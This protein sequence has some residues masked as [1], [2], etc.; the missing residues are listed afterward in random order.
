M[1]KWYRVPGTDVPMFFTQP[2]Q[3][4]LEVVEPP[5]VTPEADTPKAKAKATPTET[6]T[7]G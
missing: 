5:E 2:P 7:E 3:P 6:T 4:G 1:G